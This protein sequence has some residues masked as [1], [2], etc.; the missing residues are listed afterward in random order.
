M[1]NTPDIEHA[2]QKIIGL[3]RASQ[4]CTESV[5]DGFLAYFQISAETL[6]EDEQSLLKELVVGSFYENEFRN[7]ISDNKE[8]PILFDSNE[9]AYGT[10]MKEGKSVEKKFQFSLFGHKGIM[11]SLPKSNVVSFVPKKNKSI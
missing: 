6:S 1:D 5:P 3:I 8:N 9:N 4:M 2:G 11:V 7:Y 10:L